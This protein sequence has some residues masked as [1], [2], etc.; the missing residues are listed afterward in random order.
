MISHE[1]ECHRKDLNGSLHIVVTLCLAI[2]G[3]NHVKEIIVSTTLYFKRGGKYCE[4]DLVVTIF[5]AGEGENAVKEIIVVATL[6]C[7]RR[8][9][10]CEG[11]LS[12][13]N[14]VLH[15]RGNPVKE[16]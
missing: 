5:L 9:K 2:E 14:F 1:F 11:Y 15:E 7:G 6:C 16:I 8:G 3:E 4:R 10:L 12:C 13:D